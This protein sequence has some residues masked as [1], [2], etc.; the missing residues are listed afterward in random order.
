MLRNNFR[1]SILFLA[2]ADAIWLHR[3]LN[4]NNIWHFDILVIKPQQILILAGQWRS[5]RAQSGSSWDT[6]HRLAWA[7]PA[8]LSWVFWGSDFPPSPQRAQWGPLKAQVVPGWEHPK[9]RHRSPSLAALTV[10]FLISISGS[11]DWTAE[12][13]TVPLCL[14]GTCPAPSWGSQWWWWWSFSSTRTIKRSQMFILF[15]TSPMLLK[16][17]KKT[18]NKRN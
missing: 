13:S 5:Q 7:A 3:H 2:L 10:T 14:P 11:E 12:S 16:K 1:K 9:G 6:W 8:N 4:L 18:P 17:K 15:R